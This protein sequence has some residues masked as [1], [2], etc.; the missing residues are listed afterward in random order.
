M[1][2]ITICFEQDSQTGKLKYKSFRS[3]HTLACDRNDIWV[4]PYNK[5]RLYI[6]I[7]T[8]EYNINQTYY[9]VRQAKARIRDAASLT[10]WLDELYRKF[11]TKVERK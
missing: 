8:T 3:D 10:K 2:K 9:Y 6:G 1:N 4:D 11:L 5:T 7:M